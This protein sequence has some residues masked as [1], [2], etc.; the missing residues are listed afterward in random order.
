MKQEENKVCQKNDPVLSDAFPKTCWSGTSAE[1]ISWTLYHGDAADSLKRIKTETIDCVITSP[2]YYNLRDYQI[3]GQIGLENK[4]E[5]YVEAICAVMDEIYRVLSKDGLLFLNLGDT[6]YSGNGR[7]RDID[8]K[9]RKRRF[10][11]RPVDQS[12]GLGLGFRRK[13]LIGIPWRIAL[14]MISRQWVLRSPIIW[15]KEG[16]LPESVQDRPRRSYETIFMFAKNRKYWFDQKP[17]MTRQIADDIWT[18]PANPHVPRGI[19]TASFPKELVERCLEIGCTPHGI[20]LDPFVGS[21]TTMFAAL[22]SGRSAVGIDLNEKCCDF[23]RKIFMKQEESN[24]SR[25]DKYWQN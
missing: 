11:V 22:R 6:Y 13:T 17:L 12:G 18:I 4:V 7:S 14:A 24:V 5:D 9:S 20:V 10:G 2:P 16:S 3:Q 23:I 8:K 21:G 19:N 1:G 15:H 25:T